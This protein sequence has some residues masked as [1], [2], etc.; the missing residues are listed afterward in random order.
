MDNKLNIR[1]FLKIL[2]PK[3]MTPEKYSIINE[4]DSSQQINIFGSTYKV[5]YSNVNLESCLS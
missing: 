2:D 3:G 4:Q 1:D 5:S